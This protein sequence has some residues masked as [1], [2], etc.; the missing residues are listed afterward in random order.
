M[1]RIKINKTLG[2]FFV[3]LALS[4]CYASELPED[5]DSKKE[6]A[7]ECWDLSGVTT[8]YSRERF[9]DLTVD[10]ES[11]IAH[12]SMLIG[13]E[14]EERAQA[15]VAFLGVAI[16]EHTSIDVATRELPAIATRESRDA[17]LHANQFAHT[18]ID[19]LALA[20]AR[21]CD[22]AIAERAKRKGEELIGALTQASI[23]AL[24]HS[25]SLAHASST[26]L[27]HAR[28]QGRT[29]YA[30]HEGKLEEA[31]V[32]KSTAFMGYAEAFARASSS[33]QLLAHAY[34]NGI[35]SIR[36]FLAEIARDSVETS[37]AK[38]S[39]DSK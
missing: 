16:A 13:T 14:I 39:A 36:M 23:A 3:F 26:M 1:Y 33:A 21:K 25:T 7:A 15:L 20:R 5:E 11:G 29:L 18:F 4:T 24:D 27:G 38:S 6:G 12:I 2:V 17:L 37:S 28:S 30:V 34:I 19:I 8:S 31:I 10:E 35:H 32:S 9:F 22:V